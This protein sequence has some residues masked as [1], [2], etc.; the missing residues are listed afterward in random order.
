MTCLELVTAGRCV[1]GR[2]DR[3]WACGIIGCEGGG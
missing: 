3:D 1:S 2:V